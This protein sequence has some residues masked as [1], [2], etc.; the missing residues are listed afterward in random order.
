METEFKSG[1]ICKECRWWATF[2]CSS[3]EH[4]CAENEELKDLL[5]IVEEGMFD[6]VQNRHGLQAIYGLEFYMQPY[7]TVGIPARFLFIYMLYC[8]ESF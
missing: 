7:I 5:P 8:S 1:Q 3:W 2:L 6:N 4:R